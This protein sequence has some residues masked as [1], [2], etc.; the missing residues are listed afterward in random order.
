MKLT[1]AYLDC[2]TY[3]AQDTGVD[4]LQRC[5][6]FINDISAVWDESEGDMA[7]LLRSGEQFTVK[8]SVSNFIGA[9]RVGSATN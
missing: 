1:G 8:G 4:V 3:V 2:S 7:V 6:I 5:L 9:C